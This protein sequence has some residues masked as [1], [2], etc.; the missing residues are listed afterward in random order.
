M[1]YINVHTVR[2]HVTYLTQIE[3]Q[4]EIAL[5]VNFLNLVL[6]MIIYPVCIL[7]IYLF[8]TFPSPKQY[9]QDGLRNLYVYYSVLHSMELNDLHIGYQTQISNLNSHSLSCDHCDLDVH[10]VPS[11]PLLSLLSGS[12]HLSIVL[13]MLQF[14]FGIIW[15]I[16]WHKVYIILINCF[17]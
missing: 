9:I 15:L 2:K 16:T 6:A 1:D 3:W 13:P 5:L 7:A 12:S 4:I 17:S 10:T 8:I 14:C 11:V